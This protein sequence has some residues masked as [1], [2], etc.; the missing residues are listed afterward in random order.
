MIIQVDP[1]VGLEYSGDDQKTV[2][3]RETKPNIVV[4]CPRIRTRMSREVQDY[5]VLVE[6]G[7]NEELEL[8]D[9]DGMDEDEEDEKKKFKLRDL[10]DVKQ[11][12]L[13]NS[14]FLVQVVSFGVI[15]IGLML[16]W[17]NNQLD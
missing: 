5:I 14:Q 3:K 9:E 12:L 16:N 17:T 13:K 8:E 6:D 10:N 1:P 7:F 2:L 11:F 15:S 4:D